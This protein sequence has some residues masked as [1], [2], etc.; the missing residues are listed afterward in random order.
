MTQLLNSKTYW[1][2]I[3]PTYLIVFKV[4]V[5]GRKLLDGAVLSQAEIDH[6]ASTVVLEEILLQFELDWKFPVPSIQQEV[7]SIVHSHNSKCVIGEVVVQD[8][9]HS[10]EKRSQDNSMPIVLVEA[11]E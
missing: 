5:H 7:V 1:S 9:A 4:I 10:V 6:V 8:G 3:E 11:V 2:F